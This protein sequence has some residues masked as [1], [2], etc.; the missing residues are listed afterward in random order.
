MDVSSFWWMAAG[1]L[2]MA[3]LLTGTFY[4]LM[5][6]LGAAAAALA[7]HAGLDMTAQV[8]TAALVGGAGAILLNLKS[9]HRPIGVDATDIHIHLDIGAT[10]MVDAWDSQDLAHIKHRGAMW[11]AICQTNSKKQ[12]RETGLHKIVA[13]EGSRLVIEKI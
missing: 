12:T 1:V 13:I 11:A 3:E 9:K 8:V 7:A 10:V 5:L 4:L 6:S 2:V